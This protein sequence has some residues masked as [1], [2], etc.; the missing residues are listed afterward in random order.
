M[1]V[2]LQSD[3][4]VCEYRVDLEE[5]ESDEDGGCRGSR[6]QVYVQFGVSEAR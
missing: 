2:A 6:V 3:Q 4:V 1:S 5:G